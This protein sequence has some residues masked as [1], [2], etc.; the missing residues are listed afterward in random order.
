MRKIYISLTALLFV[1][2]M[3]LFVLPSC[4]H[5][6]EKEGEEENDEYDG[7]DKAAEFELLR[8][9]DPATGKI[10]MDKMWAAVLQTEQLKHQ[11]PQT[12]TGVSSLTWIERGSYADAVGPSNGNGRPG[13]GI[14][15]GRI[16][17]IWVDLADAT[18]K[19]VWIAGVDGGLWRTTDITATLPTWTLIN[20]YLSN[21]AVSAICQDPTNTNI[22]YF[23]TGES[24]F[25]ADAVNGNGVF[26]ST[27]HGVTWTQ[28]PS[29]STL[30][31]CSKIL[32]DAS[33]NVYVS[34]IGISVA[35][36]LQRSSDGGT[37]WTSINPFS[38]TSRIVDFEISSTGTIHVSAGLF[39]AAGIGGYK[40]NT[41]AATATT[42]NWTDPV[43][44]FPF[45]SGAAGARTEL[46]CSGNTVYASLA[47]P[48]SNNS[49]SYINQ[50]AKST[51]GG[52]NWTTTTLTSTNIS[53]LNGN[54]VG[55]VQGG[56]GWYA[57]GLAIDPSDPNTVVVASLNLLKSTDGG[58]TF[59]KITEWVGSTGQYV[60]AD[61]H[62]ITWYDNGNK[63]LIGC[64]GGVFYSAN[65]GVNFS[66]KNT[67]IRIK[68]FY[69]VAIHP[70][71]I[72]YFLAGA[73]DN[74]VHQLNGVGLT[75]SV[76]VTGGD[77]GNV[78]IDQDEP[79]YQVGTYVYA[80]FRKSTNG[81]ATWSYGPNNG[82]GQF[83]NPF[84]YDNTGN[85][86]YAGYTANNYLRW[87]DPQVGF[88]Y[89]TVPLA[90]LAGSVSS[91]TVSP[92]TANRVYFGNTAGK[93]IRADNAN[94]TPTG[95]DI[96]PAGA[97]GYVNSV[98]VGTSDQNLIT[99]ISSYGVT[100]IWSSTNGGTSWTACDGNLPDMPVYW[101]LYNPEDNTK[102][103]IATETGVWATE[104]LNGASTVW[105][106]E[107]TFPTVKT[108]MLKYRPL[109][110]TVAAATHG[111][112]IWTTTLPNISCI[113]A[114]ITT[115]PSNV[116]V[117]AGATA[118]F[119]VVA[120]G[121]P[122]L[123]Y[124]WQVSTGGPFTDIGGA[125]AA[126]YSFTT[127]AVQNGNQYRCVV[128]GN[129]APLTAT[130]AAATLTV[131]PVPVISSQ[132][133]NTTVCVGAN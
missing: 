29:T 129:C 85:K 7:P 26:K 92:Y 71:S 15:S 35:V 74:G 31:H 57:Q 5:L 118:S 126:T 23:C 68:Q 100:N 65:K 91:V 32:C 103:Y 59:G 67:G 18:G 60:H 79:Q 50:V 115:S 111:R 116:V 120:A 124:Q 12:P 72:N 133:A 61:Q 78:A 90:A 66:D 70:S 38:T 101:A 54:P 20:D 112:G 82:N 8:T 106:P 96:S 47:N 46:A 114:S 56:Q 89:T 28:L 123:T 127:T 102:A 6:S 36:G 64:D 63:L 53:D 41:N 24:F 75:T 117:C 55:G 97:T 22:M 16:R 128:T 95:T 4:S 93:V 25:N 10:P 48:N 73:Q 104:L 77:G 37:T 98:I 130:S 2:T 49:T 11:A 88:T 80:N 110:R 39:S 62:N 109:D 119:T 14:T 43:T 83:I 13:N 30:I 108:M 94:A 99:T 19:T 17:A 107:S 52:A 86:V 42:T 45:P 3:S 84:D 9:K 1:V 132:P 40:Y 69:G 131:N 105:V 51:D 121:T 21:L 58:A 81:G 27:D 34:T 125:T 33:G 76:E 44:P 113:P 87:E 122:T